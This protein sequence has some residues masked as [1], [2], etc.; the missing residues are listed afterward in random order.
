MTKKIIPE[1][2]EKLVN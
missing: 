1:C 2:V